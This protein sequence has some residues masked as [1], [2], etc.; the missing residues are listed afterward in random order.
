MKNKTTVL[1]KLT[2]KDIKTPGKYICLPIV[3]CFL[4]QPVWIIDIYKSQGF[5]VYRHPDGHELCV[6]GCGHSF[7]VID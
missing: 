4:T 3:P 7:F 6:D 2:A 5:L 1:P